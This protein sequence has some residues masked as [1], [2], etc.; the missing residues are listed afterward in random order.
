MDAGAVS[1]AVSAISTAIAGYAVFVTRAAESRRQQAKLTVESAAPS[2]EGDG[3]D[4]DVSNL[5]FHSARHVVVTIVDA[6]GHEVAS[7]GDIEFGGPVVHPHESRRLTARR[8][9]EG[10]ADPPRPEALRVR[11]E[12]KHWEHDRKIPPHESSVR[13]ASSAQAPRR[14]APSECSGSAERSQAAKP[15]QR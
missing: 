13:I 10:S 5:G 3:W 2:S 9:E 14:G 11:V 7:S 1:L 12:W 8:H 6:A 4:V 15:Q